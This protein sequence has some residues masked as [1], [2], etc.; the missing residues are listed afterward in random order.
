VIRRS[1]AAALALAALS[2]C[3]APPPEAPRRFVLVTL[4]TLRADHV[5]CYGAAE[6]ATPTLD[7]LAVEGVRF[8]TAISPV[9]LT[10]PSHATLLTGTDPP[11]HA[12]HGNGHFR[13]APDGPATLG[14]RFGE[15]GFATAAFVASFV[16]DRRFG[17][18]RGFGLYDDQMGLSEARSLAPPQRRGDVV[19][20]A[21]LA[22]LSSAPNRFFLWVHLYDPHATYDPPAPFDATFRHDPYAGEIAFA[23]QQLGRLLAGLDARFRDG[24]SMVVVTS[25]H[26]ESRGEHGEATHA[27]TLYDATQ[28]VPL[29]LRG[30]GLPAGRSVGELVRLADV[31]PTLLELADLPPLAGASGRSLLPLLRGGDAPRV[32]Y[33]ETVAGQLDL[34]WSPI[35]GLRT[36]TRKYIRAPRPELY[37]LVADPREQHDL[38]AARPDERAELD[39][40]LDARLAGA[41]P[42]AINV[43]LDAGERAQLESL[44]YVAAAPSDPLPAAGQVG[45]VDPKDGMR[46]LAVFHEVEQILSAGRPE[47]ALERLAPY[48]A[49]RSEW[50]HSLRATAA[51]A[52]GRADLARESGEM[53]IAQKPSA[54]GGHLMVA[55]ALALEHRLDEAEAAYRR[56]EEISPDTGH[57]QT[58]LGRIA[59]ERGQRDAAADHYRRALEARVPDVEAAWLLAALKLEDGDTA[60]ANELLASV[61]ASLLRGRSTALR[62][63]LA[64]RHAGR[65]DMALLRAEAGLRDAPEHL[66]LLQLQADLLEDSGDL[67]GALRVRERALALQPGDPALSNQV[68]WSLALLGARLD[69]ALELA[70]GAARALPDEPEAQDTLAAVRLARGEP[71]AALEPV[72][73]ALS[74]AQGDTRVRLL[75]RRAEA[76]ALLGRREAARADLAAALGGKPADALRGALGAQAARVQRLVDGEP[77]SAPA[78]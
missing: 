72:A 3:G 22:W 17:L 5:G 32:A 65:L 39:R 62:L 13:L 75:L 51:I 18:D 19:V 71:Q 27:Y 20:D 78:G 55:A 9:P 43:E 35:Y 7:R 70:T 14:E 40:E 28:R 50:V 21:A 64:E 57:A 77:P 46:D 68:A 73:R 61:P 44:G 60:G 74:R 2:A 36:Q 45:G 26:G 47:A 49:Q 38:A 76:Q 59:E 69:R 53:L 10:L 11:E 34:D 1:V 67:R 16:L 48:A 12:V 42:I 56:A 37:D 54:P 41:G 25:D 15:A 4:D 63:A 6:A 31:A 52:A 24:R 66:P 58:G 8:D 23:D 29:L 30:P 33:V